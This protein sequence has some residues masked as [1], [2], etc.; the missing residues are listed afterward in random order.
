MSRKYTI[1]NDE[2]DGRIKVIDCD[3]FAFSDAE[4]VKGAV[5]GALVL[6]IR[7]KDI[8]FNGNYVPI[9][10]CLQVVM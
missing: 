2:T 4:S 7:L 3:G 8:D 10:E 9:K 5:I 1:T 6:G